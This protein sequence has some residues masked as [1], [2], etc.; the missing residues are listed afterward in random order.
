MDDVA[1]N[2]LGDRS[3]RSLAASADS[4][5]RLL[6][7]HFGSRPGLVEA[8]VRRVE[9]NERQVLARLAEAIHDPIELVRALWRELTA[10]EVRPFIRLFFEAVAYSAH[11]D[12]DAVDSE[13]R[14]TEPWLAT[15]ES[16]TTRLGIPFDAVDVRLGIAVTRGLLIDVL[17]TGDV[18]APTA[19]LERFLDLWSA[20]G[21]TP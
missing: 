15:S 2:G 4:S 20:V 17:T 21:R 8:I 14:L 10:A 5:H 18:V 11:P 6:L 19:S 13:L 12:G 7:Y 16:I 9:A 1:V 3:L